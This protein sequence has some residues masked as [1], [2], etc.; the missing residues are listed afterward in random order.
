MNFIKKHI[1]SL[2][3]T[4]YSAVHSTG[5]R[6]FVIPKKGF[7]KTYA[8]YGTKF[9]SI[10]NHFVPLGSDKD[11]TVPDGVAHFL[12]HKMFEQ[13]DGSN[14]FDLF[15]KYGAN[16][17]AFTSF[18]NTCYLFSCTK[19]FDECFEHLLS[20]V[21]KPH[22][23]D[24]NIE[25]EQGIIGQEIRMYDDD[26]EWVVMFNMLRAL[27]VNNPVK[28]DIAGTVESISQINKDVLYNCYN[29]YYNPANMVVAVAGDVE[30]ERIFEIVD[31]TIK[32]TEYGKVTS[33]YPDEPEAVCQ[34][35]IEAKS[36]VA[37]PLFQIGFKDNNL[38]TG[39]ELLRREI[40]LKILLRLIAGRSSAFF[41]ENY[42]SGLIN[43][44]FDTDVMTELS[45][46]CVSFG[47]ECDNPKELKEKLMRTLDKFREIGFDKAEFERIKKAFYGSF[48]RT[49]NNVESIGNLIC[50][51]ML[52]DVDVMEF[53]EIYS[54]ITCDTMTELLNEVL[55]EENSVLSVVLPAE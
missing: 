36:L 40:A 44:T 43:D 1:E 54:T 19:Y 10:N 9:G 52:S 24:E 12:E 38:K 51:N 13:P 55:T 41:K 37:K 15:S 23:T 20:Y 14:A 32:N 16:A 22:F 48:V 27:Y 33:I 46:S 7:S 28:I 53:P 45:F 29:T 25:K 17:N 26:G 50:R 6:I 49:F 31:K 30:P 21:N 8:V 42:D 35:Y 4:L 2:G 39:S 11:I 18:T 3:E 47:G 34:K 5:L